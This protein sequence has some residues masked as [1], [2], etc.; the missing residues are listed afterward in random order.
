MNHLSNGVIPLL[1]VCLCNLLAAMANKASPC[2]CN[3][4]DRFDYEG[5]GHE[6][7]V[8]H[9]SA[10][11]VKPPHHTDK[12]VIVAHDTF[13]WQLPNTR[14]I[15]DM[16]ASK[17]YIAIIPDFFKGR[18]PWKPSNDRATYGDW[19]KTRDSKNT[20]RETDVVLNYLKTQCHAKEIGVIGFCWGGAVVHHLM[21]RYLEFKAGVSIYGI[22]TFHKD[23]YDL[24]NPTFFM[25]AE[26]DDF[27]PLD[28]VAEVERKLKEQ[29]KTDYEVKIY[30][31]QTHGFVHRKREDISPQDRPFIEEAREDMLNWLKKYI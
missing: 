18:E 21:L 11:V 14:Y 16:L 17:G 10:Y 27:V 25:F 29:C 5:R 22:I 8:G 6:V 31:G 23:N 26:N 9:I 4:G 1:V 20:S 24:K 12:A 15:A 30:P 28:Q 2:P 7:S 3:L 13:G 19:I